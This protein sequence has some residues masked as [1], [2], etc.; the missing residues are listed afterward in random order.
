M[1]IC[2][3]SLQAHASIQDPLAALASFLSFADG[4]FALLV[5]RLQ[6][7]RSRERF[8]QASHLLV[9]QSGQ[10]REGCGRGEHDRGERLY[11]V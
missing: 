11:G 5:P 3:P 9:A 1:A 10:V 6:R 2:K 8:A 4:D 7:E